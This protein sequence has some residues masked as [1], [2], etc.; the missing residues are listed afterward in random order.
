MLDYQISA[1]KIH[2]TLVQIDGCGVLLIGA[3]G[4]GKSDTALRLIESKRAVLVADDVVVL[5]VENGRLFGSPAKNIAGMLEVRGIGLVP[6]P[7]CPRTMVDFAVH[8]L[9]TPDEVTRFPQKNTENIFGVEIPRIDLYAKESSGVD[10][11]C[12][13]VRLCCPHSDIE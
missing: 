1:D 7:Y 4:S 8:L 6:Y 11:I 13:S 3:S 5:N 2:A 12:V 10:K 9:S